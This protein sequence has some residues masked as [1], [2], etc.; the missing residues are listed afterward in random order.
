MMR[1][2]AMPSLSHH[3]DSLDKPNR[4]LPE[5]KGAPP[6]SCLRQARGQAQSVRM[7]AGRPNSLKTRSNTA[8]AKSEP[9]EAMPSHARR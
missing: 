6:G 1:S 5:A 8:K 2:I 9:V 7:A 3:T 4:A